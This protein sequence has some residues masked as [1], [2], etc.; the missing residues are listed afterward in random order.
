MNVGWMLYGIF[1]LLSLI[2]IA[3]VFAGGAAW[4]G[5]STLGLAGAA[6]VTLVGPGLVYSSASGSARGA[7]LGT[8]SFGPAYAIGIAISTLAAASAAWLAVTDAASSTPSKVIAAIVAILLC[9]GLAAA[10]GA[11]RL[12]VERLELERGDRAREPTD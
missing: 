7:R 8:V 12:Q 1:A 4:F 10:P 6:L 3:L 11:L 5:T 9:A 2:D